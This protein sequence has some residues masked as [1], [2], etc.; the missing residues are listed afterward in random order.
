MALLDLILQ[1]RRQN[2]PPFPKTPSPNALLFHRYLQS[3]NP[4]FQKQHKNLILYNSA[5]DQL[6]CPNALLCRGYQVVSTYRAHTKEKQTQSSVALSS[7]KERL[8]EK[9][10]I[11]QSFEDRLEGH[12]GQRARLRKRLHNVEGLTSF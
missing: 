1:R 5:E 11:T 6:H 10:T 3:M 12:A 8:N 9:V 2:R 4:S 7:G